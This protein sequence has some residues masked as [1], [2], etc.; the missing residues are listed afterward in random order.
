MLTIHLHLIFLFFLHIHSLTM[1]QSP[2]KQ[3]LTQ[4][5]LMEVD[6]KEGLGWEADLAAH[7]K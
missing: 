6:K 4:Q 5:F 3:Y 7:V 1:D 2:K